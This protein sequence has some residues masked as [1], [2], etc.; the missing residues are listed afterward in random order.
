MLDKTDKEMYERYTED[1]RAFAAVTSTDPARKRDAKIAGF[2]RE[3]S[4]KAKLEVGFFYCTCM[5]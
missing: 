4:I 5:I 3:K 1:P 2:K